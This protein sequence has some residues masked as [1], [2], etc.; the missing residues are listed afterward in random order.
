MESLR[1]QLLVASPT[2]E[3][4]NFARTVVLVCAHD[5]EGALG[6]VLNRPAGL[7][8]ADAAG[9]LAATLRMDAELMRGGPVSADALVVLGDFMLPDEDFVAVRGTVGLMTT[10]T[11]ADRVGESAA[12]ARGFVGYAGWGPGQLESEIEREDWI[13]LD[14]DADIVF[15]DEP[16][17]AW[18]ATL[19]RQGGP[20]ALLARMPLDPSVN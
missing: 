14:F 8:A 16:E 18:A 1:G 11:P 2:L 15:S 3:D 13:V 7:R 10:G 6:L 19:E 9:E 12:R 5:D 4:P 17:V 20:L